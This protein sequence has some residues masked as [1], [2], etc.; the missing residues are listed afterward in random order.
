M[1]KIK[2]VSLSEYITEALR[3]A[4]Y[5]KDNSL[6]K[7]SCVVAEAPDLPGCYTQAENFEEARRNLIE[8]IELW[9]TVALRNNENL[10]VINNSTLLKPT[11]KLRSQKEKVF[12]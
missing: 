11:R 10:P 12:V 4:I 2:Q 5:E 1:R 7:I 3:N 6:G 9:I 8:A